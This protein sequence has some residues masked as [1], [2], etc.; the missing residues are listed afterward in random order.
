MEIFNHLKTGF[1]AIVGSI[2]HSIL[3]SIIVFILVIITGA[4]SISTFP[5]LAMLLSAILFL[6]LGIV[7]LGWIYNGL[8]G[9]D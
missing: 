9:W 1:K 7:L 2:I 5:I 8:F 3:I 6:L 4:T